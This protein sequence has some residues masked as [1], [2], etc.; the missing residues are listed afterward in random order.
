MHNPRILAKRWQS[1]RLAIADQQQHIALSEHMLNTIQPEDLPILYW[2]LAQPTGLVLGFSQKLS[3][4][5]PAML[6][7]Q[8]LPIY[9]RRAGGTAVLVGPHLLSL[10][11]VLPAG[12]PL[13]LSDIV[14]S[15]RWFGEAWVA[16]L[17]QLGIQTRTIAPNEAHA[18]RALLKQPE[19][20]AYETLMNRA[21]YGSISSYEVVADQRKVVGLDMIR[22]RTG[23]LLQAGVLLHWDT[24]LLARL[25]GHTAEEQTLL[26][27]GLR[28]RAVGLDELAGRPI[29]VEAVI[30]AFEAVIASFE[31]LPLTSSS[32]APYTGQTL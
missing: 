1:Y 20:R 29:E 23:S 19:T 26:R 21:C 24:E 10:D 12:H 3:V 22:R 16:A 13:V 6:E 7:A 25:L 28:T 4:L 5:N 18:Q 9:H 31:D 11:V 30:K 27:E 2:S 15:Y 32:A 14:E 17:K 8:G